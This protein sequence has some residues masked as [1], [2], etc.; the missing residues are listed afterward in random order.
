MK[1]VN[2]ASRNSL[3]QES[4]S[5]LLDLHEMNPNYPGLAAIIENAEYSMGLKQRPA[6]KTGIAK[7]ASLAKEAQELLGKAGR[8]TL[9]L[10]QAKE[11]AQA[12]IDLNPDNSI[13][14][15]V[16][17]EIALR[18]GQQAAVVLS[19]KDEAIYQSALADLQK[20]N[21]FDANAK[22]AQLMKNS[23]Y[24]RSAKIIKLKKRIEAQL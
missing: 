23:V 13:A 11:K 24:A 18:T 20:N 22:L 21:I 2:Y 9:L 5:S 16:L 7:A 1:Q 12:A 19:A 17:D 3:A 4:Y 6:D 14:I 15:T 10:Q 8:D